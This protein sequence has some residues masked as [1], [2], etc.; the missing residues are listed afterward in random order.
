[1]T[2]HFKHV[3]DNSR[4][5]DGGLDHRELDFEDWSHEKQDAHAE[6]YPD[7]EKSNSRKR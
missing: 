2:D 1:M 3:R 5:K 6:R 7:T 4:R